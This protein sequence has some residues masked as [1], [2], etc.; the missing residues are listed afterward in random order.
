L[1]LVLGSISFAVDASH[2]TVKRIQKEI[3]LMICVY[4][5]IAIITLAASYLLMRSMGIIGVGITWVVGNEL[6]QVE[7]A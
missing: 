2:A 5:S 3:A 4:G 6:W 7:L 1:I